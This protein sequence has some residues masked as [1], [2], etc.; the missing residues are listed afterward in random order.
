MRAEKSGEYRLLFHPITMHVNYEY[1]LQKCKLLVPI[2]GRILDYGCGKGQTVEEGPNRSLEIF[3]VEAFSFGSGTR[4]KEE[5]QR[6]S[7][8]GIR[9]KELEGMAIPFPDQHFEMVVSNQVFEH[10]V[11]LDETLKEIGRV[12]RPG[13]R[14]LCLFPS[15]LK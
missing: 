13:G 3:G 6:K 5:L 10:V 15:L 7:L 4:I 11:E 8:L 2:N 1:L 14:L 12:L 9:I